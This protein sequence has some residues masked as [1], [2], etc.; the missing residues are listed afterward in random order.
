MRK[1]VAKTGTYTD[2]EGNEKSNWT[3]VG[4]IMSND[5]GEFVILDSTVALAGVAMKQRLTNPKAKGD[6]M[7]SIFSDD[8]DGG[9]QK[10]GGRQAPASDDFEDSIPF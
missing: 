5:N 8:R 4:R 9:Q 2:R 6:V 3:N 10:G 1:I 7:C